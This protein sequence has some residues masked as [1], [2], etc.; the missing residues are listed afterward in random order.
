MSATD[1]SGNTIDVSGVT[2]KEV[3]AVDFSKLIAEIV[4]DLSGAS[5]EDLLRYVPRFAAHIHALDLP[6]ADKRALVL[7]ALRELADRC[8]PAEAREVAHSL[9]DTVVPAALAGVIDVVRGRV[10]FAPELHVA[11]VQASGNCL[12]A[13][14]ACIKK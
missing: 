9:L 2:V 12:M 3:P 13:L 4:T 11:A 1:I 5:A 10:S 6:K 8:I 7:G 14:F